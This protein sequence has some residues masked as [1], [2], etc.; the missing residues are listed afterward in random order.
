MRSPTP[1]TIV[2]VQPPPPP[3]PPPMKTIDFVCAE[4]AAG[5]EVGAK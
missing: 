3:P 1:S 4:V 2:Q 5:G